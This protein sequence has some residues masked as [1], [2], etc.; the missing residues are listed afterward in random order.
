MKSK[1][2]LTFVQPGQSGFGI[3]IFHSTV[4]FPAAAAP[5]TLN[6]N[7]LPGMVVLVLV[8]VTVFFQTKLVP[9]ALV[10]GVTI[11]AGDDEFA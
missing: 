11:G 2:T 8:S 6:R 9:V 5:V 4:F 3:V 10:E 7:P 1:L